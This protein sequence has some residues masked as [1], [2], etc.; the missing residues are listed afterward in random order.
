MKSMLE[1]LESKIVWD[2][3]RFSTAHSHIGKDVARECSP[4]QI[5][6]AVF[7]PPLSVEMLAGIFN[8]SF[9]RNEPRA[10]K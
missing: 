10:V 4:V 5:L 7:G 2:V 6:C 8:P 1:K 3:T 9:L